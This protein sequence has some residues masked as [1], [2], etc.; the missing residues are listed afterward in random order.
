MVDENG[1]VRI[2]NIVAGKFRTEMVLL[3]IHVYHSVQ[4]IILLFTA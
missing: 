3:V 1:F 2:W 4:M